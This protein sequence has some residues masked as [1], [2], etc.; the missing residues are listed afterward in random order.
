MNASMTGGPRRRPIRTVFFGTPSFA[1]PVLKTLMEEPAID[2]CLVVTRPDR[3]A[4]R[5][6][7]L[8]GSPVKELADR[9]RM[10]TYQPETFRD[11]AARAPLL[12]CRPDL[13]VVA[14]FGL[15]FGKKTLAIPRLGSINVHGSLL[16]AYRGASPIA[17]VLL[18]G[19]R[20]T[21]A[22]LMV[23][24]PGLDTGPVIDRD[25]TPILPNAT[26]ET[27]TE[28]VSHVGATLVQRSLVRFAD[29]EVAATPQDDLH[30][31]LTR[32]LRKDD[33]WINWDKPAIHLER[34]VRAM[35][36]WPRAWTTIDGE[37]L[38]IH[39]SRVVEPQAHG[40]A[41][42][43]DDG[44]GR[45]DVTTGAGM[46]RLATVQPSSRGPMSGDAFIAGRS[47]RSGARLGDTGAPSQRSPIVIRVTGS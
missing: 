40:P 30:A 37:L 10:A 32:P 43:V 39:A 23:M 24:E 41:G 11:E 18:S 14:A 4:G 22:S 27:L 19:D 15:V 9:L 2:V 13:F 33:G 20:E 44:S 47:I 34:Q 31:T 7:R 29:G 36:P 21:G 16:P 38:Q 8:T 17:A 3:L 28:A 1:V 12:G 42:T 45:F 5:G 6:R 35:W 25:V 26:S 46:L